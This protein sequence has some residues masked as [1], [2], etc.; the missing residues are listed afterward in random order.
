MRQSFSQHGGSEV[1]P[2]PVVKFAAQVVVEACLERSPEALKKGRRDKELTRAIAGPGEDADFPE[3]AVCED[4]G[5]PVPGGRLC[6]AP[7]RKGRESSPSA[8]IMPAAHVMGAEN[9]R[10]QVLPACWR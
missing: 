6:A 10:A 3:A 5:G 2:L 1:I 8:R 7:R 9:S 4:G